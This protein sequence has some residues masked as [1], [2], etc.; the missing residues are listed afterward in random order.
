MATVTDPKASFQ[1]EDSERRV[2]HPLQ[3]LRSTIR[4]YIAAEGFAVLGLYLALWFWIGLLLDFGF[5]K[6]FGVDWVQLLPYSL[7][8]VM[9]AGLVTGLV[10]LVAFKVLLR[11]LRE[12][13]DSA[14]A[15]LLERR[16]PTVLG[17]RL[18]TAVELAD[19]RKAARYGYSQPMVDQTIRDAADRVDRLE[20]AQVFDWRRLRRYAVAV[21]FLTLGIFLLVG[22]V[23]CLAA[24]TGVRSF[25]VGFQNV[26]SIWFERNIL[27][28]NTIWPRKCHLELVNFPESGDLRVGRNASPPGLRVRALKWVLA[29]STA[30]EGWRALR[31]SDLGPNLLGS[32]APSVP[33]PEDWQ[34]WSVDR[35]ES[36][37]ENREVVATLNGDMVSALRNVFERLEERA[38]S[39]GMARRL[40]KLTIPNQVVVYYRGETVRSEQ[41]L[42]KQSDSE[43]SGVLSDLK[44]SVRFTANGEDYYTPYKR[45]TLVPPPGLIE[46][47]CDEER[48]AYLHQRRPPG[49]TLAD[50]KGKKTIVKGLPV[51]LAATL[52]RI[53]VAAGT[54]VV[55]YGKTDKLL[56]DVDG[57]RMRPREGSAP[58]H[59]PITRNHAQAFEVRFENVT[60]PLDFDFDFTDTDNVV[61]QRHV[62][63]K[64][65]E[66][67]PPDVD[68][69]VEVI[70]KNNQG[71]LATTS[72]RIPFSGKLRD[73][74]GLSEVNYAYTVLAL[75][76]QAALAIRPAISAFQFLPRGLGS[77]LVAMAYLAWLGT[78]A[79]AVVEEPNQSAEKRPLTAFARA[80]ANESTQNQAV[81]N[82]TLDPEEEFFE[83]GQL[84]LKVSEDP[85]T[86]HR[87]R[88]RL[89]V[90]ALDNNVDTGPGVGIS[91]E[92]FTIVLVS[93]NELLLE[94][95]KE[96]ESLHVKLE[97][98]VNKLKD[99]RNKL[100]QVILE[101]PSLRAEEFS[102]MALRAD[103]IRGVIV[104]GG[105][106]SREI[107][108][109]YRKILKE[110]QVNRVRSKIIEKV[111]RSICEPLDLAINQEFVH[112]EESMTAFQKTL[113]QDKKANV[114]A[115]NLARVQL[116]QVIDRLTRIL[117]AMGDIT[118]INKLIEQ[119]TMIEK[120]ERNAYERFKQI[121]DRLQD[122][123]LKSALPSEPEEKKP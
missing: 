20:V 45:I 99:A 111:Q 114:E 69:V 33:L 22:T 21:V 57:I 27:L 74:H 49:G 65:M 46:L 81:L 41:T 11:L 3:R 6:V 95:A 19:P 5:F 30:P 92:K 98:T 100:E 15:L 61:G 108:A 77:E 122:E 85:Q 101:M 96:E 53:D 31:W 80:L 73:D 107:Y 40:R 43:Y 115:G 116:E 28:A 82:L 70:R 72:A 39:L 23:S 50:L 113:D 62:T 35:I 52:S 83:V 68:A 88:L 55:L 117:D 102:P 14:L 42:K 32:D 110:L 24:R 51:S 4:S 75:D 104:R 29:D 2:R 103:E 66:D 12:F 86:Q 8:A 93:E 90:E 78:A 37:L 76:A 79:K 106:V 109:D 48:P 64:P 7:R 54:N 17:D 36:Q 38:E 25:L 34:Q 119:L 10:A 60:A 84:G 56:R 118:T 91:K 18:I 9:L 87:Y 71:Y 112:S 63:I 1:R 59:A 105:D 120:A 97:D 89:W 58:I 13:R 67:M 121:N 47:T 16:F 123:L 26:S 94:I 44:E